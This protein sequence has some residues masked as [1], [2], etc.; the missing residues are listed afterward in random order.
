MTPD[1]LEPR[2]RAKIRVDGS[3]CWLWTASLNRGGYGQLG[4]G[5]HGVVTAHRY[6]YQ[7][8]V[9][10]VPRGVYLCHTCDVPACVNPDHLYEGDARDN[11][12]DASARGLLRPYNG[13]VSHCV[14]GHEYTP[15]NTYRAP[16]RPKHRACLTCI[17]ARDARRKSSRMTDTEVAS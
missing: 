10:P 17:R 8:L 1:Q 3:G 2:V 4:M 16:S 5:G 13:G 9:R 7:Q 6:V 12:R 14:N 11:G 15:E